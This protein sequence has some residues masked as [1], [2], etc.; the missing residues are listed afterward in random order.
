[1]EPILSLRNVTKRYPGVVALNNFSIDFLPGEVHALLGEN[2]AGKSTLIKTI[3]GAIAPEEGEIIWQGERFKKM[4]PSLSRERGIEVIYQEFNL[5][6]TLSAA[7]NICFGDKIG[8]LVDYKA[9]E[10]KAREIFNQFKIDIDPAATVESLSTAH[11]QIVEIAK[12]ISKNCRLLIMDEPSAPLTV[13]EVDVMFEIVRSLQKKGITIIYI[14]HRMDEIFTIADRVTV[15]RDGQYIDT[16]NVADTNRDELIRLMVG[17]ELSKTYPSPQNNFEEELLRVENLCGNGDRDISLTLRK[18]EILG[19]AGLIGAGRTEFARVLYGADKCESGRIF[20]EGREL[21]IRNTSDAI[22]EGIGLIP[23]DRK[24]QGCFLEKSIE[25]NIG[26]N[27]IKQMSTGMI[28]DDRK[29]KNAAERFRDTLHI[30]TPSLAQLVQNLS[31]GNQQKV[32]IAKTLAGQSK[33]V[34]FDEPTRGIDVGAKQ[35]IYE[36]MCTL[37]DQGIGIIMISSDMEELLGMSQRILVMAGGQITG[38]LQKSEF[39]QE[40]VLKYA[41]NY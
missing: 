18:G 19:I 33:V 34:I 9:M 10:A 37:A 36:L 14:S 41:S 2:G 25:W 7:E 29:L 31:G 17:R 15:M 21:H 24:S 26:S 40:T 28:V 27:T 3:S 22:R 38:E 39:S 1:M 6:D 13:N 4:T 23:E 12:A 8:R 30:K 16:R 5:V 20:L 35:E 11:K 32:V